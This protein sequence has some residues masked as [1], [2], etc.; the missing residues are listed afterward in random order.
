[1]KDVV[2]VEKI[3]SK[4]YLI[5]G[6][7]V[8]LDRDLAALYGV[9]TRVLKQAV[10][11]NITRFPVDFM[12]ELSRAEFNNLRSQIVTSSWGGIRYRPMAFTEQ[13]V[14]MLS[15]VLNSERAV[16]VNIQ[17]MRAF[18]KLR[19]MLTTHE[20]LRRKIEEMEQKYDQQFQVVFDAIKLLLEAEEKPKPKIGFTVKERVKA[21]GRKR[22]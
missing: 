19:Q 17:I 10:K 11:R 15:S 7:K 9:E 20:D 16:Q 5:R 18:T 2:P 6:Q 3:T 8:M 13:G 21:Y 1:M 12:F 14:A 4:I 22:G